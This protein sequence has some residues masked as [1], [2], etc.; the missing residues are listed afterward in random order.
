[1]N[2]EFDASLSKE[3]FQEV[4]GK[5]RQSVFAHDDNFT[6]QALVDSVQYG[7]QAF[8]LEVNSRRDVLLV[9]ITRHRCDKLAGPWLEGYINVCIYHLRVEVPECIT[10]RGGSIYPPV[11]FSKV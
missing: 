2:H 7:A 11:G 10:L 8:S 4:C 3:V 1:M 9:D 6:D 5:A